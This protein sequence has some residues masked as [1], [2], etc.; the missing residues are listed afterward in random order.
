MITTQSNF[1]LKLIALFSFLI[2]GYTASAQD[3]K[4]VKEQTY[5][6]SDNG[7]IAN[8]QPYIDAMNNSDF[9]YHR[10]LHKRHTIVF[11]TGVK[12][13]LFSATEISKKGISIS[14]SEYPENFESSRQEPV[15]ALG[16]NNFIIEYHS[17]SNKENKVK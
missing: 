12:V 5:S 10:L 3:Q 14:L 2:I 7:G 17:S 15:F 4:E 13:E 11:Q 1:F 8:I 6:I 16:A 9:K